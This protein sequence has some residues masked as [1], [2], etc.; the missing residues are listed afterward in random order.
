MIF[1][2]IQSEDFDVGGIYQEMLQR[3]QGRAG[4]IVTFTG[5]A[6][7]LIQEHR[8]LSALSIEHYPG[9]TENALKQI[10]EQA[11][12]RFQLLAVHVIHRIGVLATGEQIVHVCTA[13]VHRKAAFDA[14]EMIM[15]YLK[16]DAPFW[17]KELWKDGTEGWVEQKKSDRD[18]LTRWSQPE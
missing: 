11:V 14:A 13:A 17:K 2:D 12:E 8:E 6:R 4:A 1:V 18:A 5:N 10:A 9:M 16:N 3:T 7:D 15:D